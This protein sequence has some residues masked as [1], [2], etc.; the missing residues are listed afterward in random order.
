MIFLC[1]FVAFNIPVVDCSF[2]LLLVA[3]SVFV[4]LSNSV[5]IVFVVL[6]SSVVV[7]GIVVFFVSVY[8]VVL[9]T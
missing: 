9:S 8:V 7:F 3:V 2:V 6:V 1:V 4:V 5:V